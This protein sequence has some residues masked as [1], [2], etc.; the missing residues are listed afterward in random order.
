MYFTCFMCFMCHY[1]T[2][3]QV[4]EQW[5][6]FQTNEHIFYKKQNPIKSHIMMNNNVMKAYEIQ[7]ISFYFVKH[8]YCYVGRRVVIIF[9]DY[10]SYGSSNDIIL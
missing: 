10:T 6:I 9:I 3:Y 4:F 1:S 8:Y 2:M 7:I 5:N